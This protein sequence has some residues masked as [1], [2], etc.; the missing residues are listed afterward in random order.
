MDEDITRPA[1]SIEIAEL[2]DCLKGTV[3]HATARRMAYE[4]DGHR[5]RA[6]KTEECV[7]FLEGL[8]EAQDHVEGEA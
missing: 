5:T 8:V 7:Q 3:L 2:V 6:R 1:T 4:L